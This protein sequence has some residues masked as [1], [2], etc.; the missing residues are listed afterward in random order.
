MILFP[1]IFK[2][3][4][5]VSGKYQNWERALWSPS[6]GTLNTVARFCVAHGLRDTERAGVCEQGSHMIEPGL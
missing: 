4:S 5:E 6:T 1:N 2:S 3:K